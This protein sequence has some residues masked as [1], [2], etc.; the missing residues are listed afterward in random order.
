[1]TGILLLRDQ[2]RD[3]VE[4]G[5]PG[6]MFSLLF[7]SLRKNT[8]FEVRADLEELANKASI[9]ALHDKTRFE[10]VGIGKQMESDG[11][12]ILNAANTDD[13]RVLIAAFAQY[14]CQL[15]AERNVLVENNALMVGLAIAAEVDDDENSGWGTTKA[16]NSARHKLDKEARSLG[17][18]MSVRA[19]A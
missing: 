12:R 1:M 19:A 2:R 17:Y 7:E 5:L 10:Q 18:F 4:Q 13:I 16:I 9:A 14:L 11:Y 6:Y 8:G 3:I 15:A